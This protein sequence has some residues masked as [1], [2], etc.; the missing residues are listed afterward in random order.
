MSDVT[1]TENTA[2]AATDEVVNEG[3]VVEGHSGSYD[4]VPKWFMLTAQF[5]PSAKTCEC[6]FEP[7]QTWSAPV[8]PR[9]NHIVRN[10]SPAPI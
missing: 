7:L 2:P 9:V 8:M 1:N 4:V 3:Q 6:G 10:T 5:D